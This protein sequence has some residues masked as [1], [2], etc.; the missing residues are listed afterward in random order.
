MK[1][2]RKIKVAKKYEQERMKIALREK[3]PSHSLLE[4]KSEVGGKEQKQE[5]M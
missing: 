2:E 3:S 1:R 4:V 5:E